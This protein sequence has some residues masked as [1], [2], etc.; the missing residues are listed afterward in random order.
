MDT[1]KPIKQYYA[2]LQNQG[3]TD[4]AAISEKL[5]DYQKKQQELGL[6]S[7]NGFTKKGSDSAAT[8]IGAFNVPEQDCILWCINHYLGLNRSQ[9]VIDKSCAAIRQYGTGAGTSA[10]S[11]G[12]SS[13]HKEIESRIGKLMDKEAVLLFPTG[14]TANLGCLSIL[15]G[16]NDIILFDRECHASMIDGIKLS[17]KK[18]IPF[19][20]NSVEDLEDKIA[21]FTGKYENILVVLESAYSMSGDLAPLKEICALKSKY[22]FYM[23]VDEAHTFGIYGKDGAGYCAELGVSS[24]VDFIVS[25]LS[26]ATAS[27]G[28]FVATQAKY[29]PLIMWG[30]NSYIFQACLSPGDAAT[31]LASLDEI[32]NNPDLV[33]S[34]HEK[35]KYMR[36]RLTRMGF[37]LGKSQSPII[38]IYIS[39]VQTLMTFNRELFSRGIFSVSV[40][41]P[42]V[43]PKEGRIR[44]ILNTSHTKTQIDKTVE[45]LSE[46]A[47][48]YNIISK[49]NVSTDAQPTFNDYLLALTAKQEELASAEK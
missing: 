1:F 28:G 29:I 25:T 3:L 13:L 16:K 43:K 38:P 44:L 23:Y 21:K 30:A 2:E 34:L 45:I 12:M 39:D 4:L 49:Q 36:D 5:Y 47:E 15:P 17:G 37:D 11:G 27:I 40:V 46:L 20:H 10:M 7:Q 35:N 48:K 42:A 6:F 26:K 9:S 18:W 14:Y 41:Y 24:D 22:R 19:D 31:I 32:K 33:K 8:I